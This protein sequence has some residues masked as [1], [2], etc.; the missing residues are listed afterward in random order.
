MGDL[1]VTLR[2][3]AARLAA[4]GPP[5]RPQEATA[6]SAPE[7]PA[8]GADR[9]TANLDLTELLAM[10]LDQFMREGQLLEVRVPW[11]DVTLWFVPQELDAEAARRAGAPHGRVWTASELIALMEAPDRTLAVVET[12]TRAKLAVDGDLVEVRPRTLR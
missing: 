1:N 4:A 8:N 3:L 10:P 6:S 2:A 5:A 9:R 7:A 12:I 11:L